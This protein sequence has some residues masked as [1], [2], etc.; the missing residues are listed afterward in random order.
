MACFKTIVLSH[1]EEIVEMRRLLRLLAMLTYAVMVTASAEDCGNLK[2]QL[3]MN[4]CAAAQFQEVDKELNKVYTAY[5]HRLDEFQKSQFRDVELAWV[6]YR[7]LSCAYQSS[8]VAGGSVH[9]LI[10]Q[11]CL[12]EKTRLRLNEITFLA[13]CKEGDLSCPAWK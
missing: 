2:T 6:K 3:D 9:P 7:D 8:G 5:R 4:Q 12:A 1:N 10:L 11:T 13:N